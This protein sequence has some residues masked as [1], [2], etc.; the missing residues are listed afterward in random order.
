MAEAP[1]E[2][3]AAHVGWPHVNCFSTPTCSLATQICSLPGSPVSQRS[4]QLG[5]DTALSVAGNSTAV[6]TVSAS[7]S[8]GT[9]FILLVA[10]P[11]PGPAHTTAGKDDCV[12]PLRPGRDCSAPHPG[13]LLGP[14][15]WASH[16]RGNTHGS[17]GFGTAGSQGLAQGQQPTLKR[18]GCSAD[19]T[20]SLCPYS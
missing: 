4:H 3:P 13:F 11:C 2:V 9:S 5:K 19:L 20:A 14:R 1:D 12:H 7:G 15:P 17:P 18:W 16:G 6:R 10:A 8:C